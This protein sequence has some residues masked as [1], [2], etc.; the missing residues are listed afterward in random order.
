MI[1]LLLVFVELWVSEGRSRRALYHV[2]KGKTLSQKRYISKLI[3]FL[4]F[5]SA[6]DASLGS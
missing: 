3:V 1:T 5:L 4:F 2:S 6:C